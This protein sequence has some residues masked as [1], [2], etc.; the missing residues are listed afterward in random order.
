MPTKNRLRA[1]DKEQKKLAAQPIPPGFTVCPTSVAAGI[2]A[3]QAA[4]IRSLYE[5][6]YAAAR[7]DAIPFYLR[8]ILGTGN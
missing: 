3:Q 8:P 5:H 4:S 6:A 7:R 2:G 1:Y